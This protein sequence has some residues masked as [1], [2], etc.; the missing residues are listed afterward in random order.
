[1]TLTYT[2]SVRTSSSHQSVF[3]RPSKSPGILH[4]NCLHIQGQAQVPAVSQTGL[5]TTSTE[6]SSMFPESGTFKSIKETIERILPWISTNVCTSLEKKV[7]LPKGRTTSCPSV[8]CI[9]CVKMYSHT[10]ISRLL[11]IHE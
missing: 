4:R 11:Y 3:M 2:N 1:M 8:L 6:S 9:T 5:N 10:N 7:T